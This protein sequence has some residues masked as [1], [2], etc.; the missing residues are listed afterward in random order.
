M[1]LQNKNVIIYGAGGVIGS[2]IAYAFAREGAKVFLTGHKIEPLQTV[3][4][5]IRSAGGLAEVDVVD[6]TNE[7]S[8][9]KHFKSVEEKAGQ[10]HVSLNAA[11]IAQTGV[12]GIR[13]LE[14]SP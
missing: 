11:G 5:S 7:H 2:A 10:I 4:E 13:L 6:A 8:V 1:Q 12:Q 3:A 14:L 9:N